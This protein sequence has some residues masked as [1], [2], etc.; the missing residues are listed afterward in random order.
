MESRGFGVFSRFQ[1]HFKNECSDQ[2]KVS[3]DQFW[4]ESA[5][6]Y[7]CSAG[8]VDSESRT[9]PI[10]GTY[11]SNYLDELAKSRKP[12]P[13]AG[14][15]PLH[16]CLN[17]YALKS[18]SVDFEASIIRLME[19]FK[20]SEI[21]RFGI[22]A[23]SWAGSKKDARRLFVELMQARG[24]KKAAKSLIKV[25]RSSGLTFGGFADAGGGHIVLPYHSTSLF[26]QLIRV[27]SLNSRPTKCS[28]DSGIILGLTASRAPYWASRLTLS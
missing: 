1:Q 15:P 3:L 25:C 27:N 14:T 20:K 22:R 21:K 12:F 16:P 19:E 2:T 11:R 26:L 5:R 9:F 28:G 4:D 13:C 8:R 6:E 17:E 10:S 18:R 7:V 23:D 24:F